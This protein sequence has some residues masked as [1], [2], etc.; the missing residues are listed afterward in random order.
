LNEITLCALPI[1]VPIPFGIEIQA[2]NYN[3]TFINKMDKISPAHGFWVE[4][5]ADVVEQTETNSDINTIVQ[6]LMALK[7][8]LTPCHDPR[9]AAFKNF[10]N[11]MVAFGP[12]IDSTLKGNKYNTEQASMNSFFHRNPTPAWVII[13]DEDN[14]PTKK[15]ARIPIH[16]T[17]AYTNAAGGDNVPTTTDVTPPAAAIKPPRPLGPKTAPHSLATAPPKFFIQLIETMKSFLAPQQPQ[18][19]VVESRDHKKL[20]TL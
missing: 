4:V 13:I 11:A 9:C 19:I 2:C 12:S 16:G 6:R 20:P 10:R 18:K 3:D 8:L 17:S 7:A 1:L 5:I 14:D 15:E